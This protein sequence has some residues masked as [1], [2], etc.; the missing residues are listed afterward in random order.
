MAW[1]DR[2][3]EAALRA[4][5]GARLTFDFENVT[6]TTELGGTAFT[7]PDAD[8]TFVQRTGRSG[9]QYPLRVIFW[10]DDYDL[11]ALVF[12]SALLE[13]GTFQLEHP[14]YGV[15]DVVPFGKITRRDDL[16]TAAN[17]TIIEV[18]FWETI[19]TIYPSAQTDPSR[20]VLSAV[21]EF[22][23]SASEAFAGA[24]G[25]D[26]AIERVTLRNEYQALLGTAQEN[27]QGIADSQD[28]VRTQ[29]NAIV[30][31][32]NQGIDV[33]ISDPSTLA[34]Q[35]TQLIQAPARALTDIRARLS[36]YRGLATEITGGEDAQSSNEFHT[37]DL[38]AT[39]YVTGSVVSVV[40]TQFQ[41]KPEAL[42]AAEDVLDQ[43]TAVT[44]WRDA[45]FD[46]LGE[47]D[48]GGAYQQLQEAVA[49]A[50]GFLVQISFSL[51][52]EHRI[53]LD[54]SR[55]IIDLAAELY[56]SVDDQLDFLIS[57]NNLSGSEILELPRGREIVYYV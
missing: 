14:A 55:T 57:S 13:R 44:N 46:A 39:S 38:Y 36:S 25:L 42:L 17:Q 28:D 29:F 9:R 32:V 50:A 41:T 33:L 15:V 43:L 37:D 45:N 10:G 18:I 51:R 35:T 30:D 2:L 54:R 24:L 22:N 31:S 7:F 49:L 27:L 8:G 21:D 53:V 52:Q 20:A 47:I 56:G 3:R 1:Q 16:K 12:Q 4:P 26:T 5:S 23:A 11:E 48:T 6:E 34:F 40:N 19:G